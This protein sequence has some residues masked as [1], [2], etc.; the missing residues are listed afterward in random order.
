M[1]M[2]FVD[3]AQR[4]RVT[5]W[6]ADPDSPDLVLELV[7]FV[8]G[9]EAGRVNADQLRLDLR[10][11]GKF[12]QG[13]HGFEFKFEPP[14]DPAADYDV[15]VCTANPQAVLP[16]GAFR[17]A[18]ET[19]SA[20]EA[21]RSIVHFT[22]L[23]AHYEQP[24][25]PAVRP[26]Y[27]VHVG[28][29][30]TGTKYLQQ[31][32]SQFRQRLRDLGVY[33]P[34]EWWQD[35]PI[36]GHHE[37][38]RQLAEEPGPQIGEIFSQLNACGSPVVLLSSEGFN[39]V[40]VSG[41]ECLRDATEGAKIEIVFY[42]RRWSDWIPSQ[43][44]QAVKEG[45]LQTFPEWYASLLASADTY[46]GIRQDTLIEKFASVF[47]K[48]NI[49]LVSYSN[50][51]DNNIDLFDHFCSQILRLPVSPSIKGGGSLVHESMGVFL[52]EL[53]RSLNAQ[54]VLRGEEP[55]EHVF[56]AHR[57]IPIDSAVHTDIGLLYGVMRNHLGETTLDDDIFFLRPIYTRLNE[58]RNLLVSPEYGGEV[59]RKKRGLCRYVRSEYLMEAGV[60][61]ALARVS[62]MLRR[63]AGEAAPAPRAGEHVTVAAATAR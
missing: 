61:G 57:G 52:T 6:A 45:S 27:I 38:A 55:G 42:A 50:L 14:L 2:G 3:V 34:S 24:A 26:R 43:W 5:G 23:S 12:G 46:L 40:P 53:I 56:N 8:N 60:L 7:I 28:I 51:I 37:L 48:Q 9:R 58:Y 35:E 17:I 63:P 54:C 41:L 13:R 33:Y 20:A 62:Q 15:L 25:G 10:K 30:K 44:Q 39:T 31:H 47:G 59:F 49:K 36:F 29:P 19:G 1:R 16:R 11:S 22:D 18:R 32:F 21:G 4:D